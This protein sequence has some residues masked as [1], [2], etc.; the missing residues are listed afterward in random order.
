MAPETL[1]GTPEPCVFG[2]LLGEPR[3]GSLSGSEWLC[4]RCLQG[5]SDRNLICLMRRGG[6]Q[7]GVNTLGFMK[8]PRLIWRWALCFL[9]CYCVLHFF[10][11]S[12]DDATYLRRSLV[13]VDI[14]APTP[15]WNTGRKSPVNLR[16]HHFLFFICRQ[17]NFLLIISQI[18]P[19]QSSTFFIF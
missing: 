4:E 19:N 18:D 3:L 9:W 13:T 10:I 16:R 5:S 15:W 12:D 7:W 8:V 17:L 14:K 6:N 1:W 2:V 11:A